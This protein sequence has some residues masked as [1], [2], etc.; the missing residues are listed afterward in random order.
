M[1]TRAP[2]ATAG[3]DPVEPYVG[4]DL[5]NLL[6]RR[7]IGLIHSVNPLTH[8][9]N[10]TKKHKDHP[11]QVVASLVTTLK[12]SLVKPGNWTEVEYAVAGILTRILDSSNADTMF[13][14][15]PTRAQEREYFIR[16]GGVDALLQL[17]S[18]PWSD[19]DAR[20]TST[21]HLHRKSELWNE[22][23]V[24][25]REV[26]Y[27]LPTSSTYFFGMNHII[28]LFTMLSHESVF[29]NSL[30]LLEEILASRSDTFD[31]VQV[32]E[33]ES[34]IA[35]FTTRQLSHFCRILSL[36]LFEPEDRQLMEGSHVLR[37]LELI[38]L[39]RDRMAKV[40]C[41]VERNQSLVI[42]MP[43]IISRLVQ[44]LR[45]V[46][47][48]PGLTQ[49]LQYNILAQNPI[50][51]E[52]LHLVTGS[53]GAGEWTVMKEL[54]DAAAAGTP[55]NNHSPGHL[56]PENQAL[57]TE[58]LSVF[59]NRSMDMS[60]LSG[61]VTLAQSLGLGPNAQRN[62]ASNGNKP[63]RTPQEAK[64]Q[65]MLYSVLLMPHLV[66][67]FFVLCTLLSGRRKIEVQNILCRLNLGP[68]LLT[69]FDRMCWEDPPF[70]G[71]NPVEHIHG[72]N[73]DCNPESAV[74]VQFLRLVHNFYDR[75][76]AG[77]HIKKTLLTQAENAA[78]A[79]NDL[80]ACAAKP[81]QL[82][83]ADAGI[84]SR[85]MTVM[86]KE[87]PDSIYRFWLS[88]CLEAFLRGTGPR[89]Q[90]FIA[91]GGVL[92]HTA[93]MVV[94]CGQRSGN[95]VLQ[96]AFD[97]LGEIVKANK[98]TLQIIANTFDDVTFTLFTDVIMSS[99]IDS[100]VFIRSLYMSEKSLNVSLAD[101]TLSNFPVVSRPGYLFLN[102]EESTYDGVDGTSPRN[103]SL[104]SSC[105]A[106]S[107]PGIS[108]GG[109]EVGY[110]S[111][112]WVQFA[113]ELLIAPRTSVFLGRLRQS[114][115][116][117][118]GQPNGRRVVG[119]TMPAAARNRIAV[120]HSSSSSPSSGNSELNMQPTITES[121]PSRLSSLTSMLEGLQ[122]M[123]S[124]FL[125]GAERVSEGF[126][127]SDSDCND[128]SGSR[129]SDDD[130]QSRN[131]LDH[132]MHEAMEQMSIEE[133]SA[134]LGIEGIDTGAVSVAASSG[135]NVGTSLSVRAEITPDTRMG[136]YLSSPSAECSSASV[137]RECSL[138]CASPLRTVSESRANMRRLME[139]L[140]NYKVKIVLKL[141]SSISI[142]SVNH[143]NICCLNT[144]ILICLLS[145][146]R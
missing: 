46:N 44:V 73:C 50:P 27:A 71:A 56:E 146:A 23:L 80:A 40:N 106:I 5:D 136:G 21:T 81:L 124:R 100:N 109:L 119:R 122:D 111:H 68:V 39:R 88:S 108:L 125:S 41:I 13:A 30:N 34:L 97:L 104:A 91:R 137:G 114:I 19:P 62:R 4:P 16:I 126:I 14:V 102:Q 143:E 95:N 37:S 118:P 89:E 78:I 130:E 112:S 31:L 2:K 42:A 105:G 61:F 138:L 101:E 49:L 59:S 55:Y 128:D 74:R 20:M 51:M 52:L 75:D 70:A 139:F 35:K 144:A 140:I 83:G 43:E 92:E 60:T 65:L 67:V 10:R 127:S 25:L 133:L 26:A 85:I 38:Q 84:I 17:F 69:M 53:N 58:V 9:F 33:L 72:P 96:T 86:K 98:Y 103:K 115:S 120:H 107:A 117:S 142:R 131:N 3:A 94:E 8:Y 12:N 93:K 82:G 24:I 66:E 28:F 134:L 123:A 18:K 48:G 129:D 121:S 132:D 113:P 1:R 135:T 54:E 6:F 7:E 22:V 36:T 32:P 90:L 87:S 110:L 77:N 79:E 47:Y 29:E 45:I 63:S 15:T 141:L 116:R 11:F 57:A 76:F 99:L 64:R 145:Y